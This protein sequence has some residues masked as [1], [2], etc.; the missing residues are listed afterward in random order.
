M[1]KRL[2]Y[3]RLILFGA[4]LL[5]AAETAP[6]YAQIPMEVPPPPMAEGRTPD[7][8][9]KRLTKA[10]KLTEQQRA[11]ILPVLRERSEAID[12]LFGD[13]SVPMR[14]RFPKIL[15]LIDRSN[16]TIRMIL[17]G[18]QQKKFDKMVTNEKKRQET[19]PDDGP[20]PGDMPPPP[21]Q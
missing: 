14:E 5:M 13:K 21:P 9:L 19:G 16:A 1:L 7:E 20:P 8:E 17:D 15:E 4:F 3:T 2:P 12:R 18:P 11:H 10:L 6:V